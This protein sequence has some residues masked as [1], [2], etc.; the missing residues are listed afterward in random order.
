MT[1]T[2]FRSL[3]VDEM[4]STL[5]EIFEDPEG[6]FEEMG[7]EQMYRFA[8]DNWEAVEA[9]FDQPAPEVIEP[10]TLETIEFADVTVT[11]SG[12]ET[13]G[14]D[15]PSLKTDLYTGRPRKPGKPAT[16]DLG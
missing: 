4:R 7:K 11:D 15:Q 13:A 8:K 16:F 2:E 10:E 5:Q 6:E 14:L 3:G 9:F 1:K 12:E